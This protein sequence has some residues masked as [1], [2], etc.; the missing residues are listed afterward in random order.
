M[1]EPE[2]AKETPEEMAL[3]FPCAMPMFATPQKVLRGARHMVRVFYT[4][5][6]Y[7]GVLHFHISTL[8]N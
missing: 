4:K 2:D 3:N 7:P 8:T 5:F 6:D 1:D